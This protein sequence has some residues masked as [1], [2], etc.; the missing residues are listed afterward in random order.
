MPHVNHQD[1]PAGMYSRGAAPAPHPSWSFLSLD[2]DGNW[3]GASLRGTPSHLESANALHERG[4]GPAAVF[5]HHCINN[6]RV[7]SLLPFSLS[8]CGSELPLGGSAGTPQRPLGSV[9]RPRVNRSFL[10]A[11]ASS[12]DPHPSMQRRSATMLSEP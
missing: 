11:A 9:L 5:V 8:L 6:V 2:Q 7:F 10:G 4:P 1:R 3:L 12:G